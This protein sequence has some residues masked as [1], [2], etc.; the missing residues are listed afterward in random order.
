VSGGVFEF[1]QD[2]VV[3]LPTKEEVSACIG[4]MMESLECLKEFQGFFPSVYSVHSI[5]ESAA[6]QEVF[7]GAPD[8]DK[9]KEVGG[10][11]E[12]SLDYYSN[13]KFHTGVTILAVAIGAVLA[14]ILSLL[15]LGSKRR[16]V[17]VVTWSESTTVRDVENHRQGDTDSE[18]DLSE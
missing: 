1:Q 11:D 3:L 8:D 2:S 14:T 7:T 9:T 12:T 16:R 17:A 13:E 5:P 6:P 15:F 10:D 18:S 4:A